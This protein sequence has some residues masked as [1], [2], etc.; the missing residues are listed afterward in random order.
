MS[1]A[2][3]SSVLSLNQNTVRTWRWRFLSD[4]IDGLKDLLRSGSPPV[5]DWDQ[6]KKDIFDVLEKQPPKGQATWDGKS[7]AAELGISDDIVGGSFERK[8][9]AFKGS[10][11]GASALISTSPKRR[12]MS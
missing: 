8:G 12:R 4:G 11:P 5:Y 10:E 3:I 6:T 9:Y 2:N 1:D 7:V